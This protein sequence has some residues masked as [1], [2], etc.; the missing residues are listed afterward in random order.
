[1]ENQSDKLRY[2]VSNQ[3]ILGLEYRPVEKV[4][5]TVEGFYKQYIYYPMSI[6]EGISTA[7]KGTNFGQIGDELIES[8][9][10]GRAY[11]LEVLT[12]IMEMNNLNLTATYTFFRS[13][14]TDINGI[15]RSSSWDT[16]HM[17]NLIASCKLPKNWDIAMRWRFI[18][19]APYTPI[20]MDKSSLKSAWNITNQPYLDYS[21]YNSKRLNNSHQLDI[22]IDKEFYFKK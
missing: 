9:G 2:T 16:K 10:K 5:M 12:K 15:Y 21:Q 22:R 19:G 8:T 6:D 14:F 7:S 11:G 13:E 4:R 18:G 17:V 20:D 3:A 1:M